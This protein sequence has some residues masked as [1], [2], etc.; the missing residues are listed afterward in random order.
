MQDSGVN[1]ILT[2]CLADGGVAEISV[3]QHGRRIS[4]CTEWQAYE[5]T[6]IGLDDCTIYVD[7]A[8]LQPKGGTPQTWLWS[9]GFFAG[10]VLL[11]VV[12]GNDKLRG[13]YEIVVSPAPQK[14]SSSEYS[15]MLDEI[16]EFKAALMLGFE[17]GQN[18]I[19]AE[20]SYDDPQLAYARLKLFGSA[21][22]SALSPLRRQPQSRLRY[23]REVVPLHRVRRIDQTTIRSAL[24][25]PEALRVLES[26]AHHA[27]VAK[28]PSFN[29]PSAEHTVDIP[30][31]WTMLA[32]VHAFHRRVKS[33]RRHFE[34]MLL[35]PSKDVSRGEFNDRLP[36]RIQYLSTLE[37]SLGRLI[38]TYPFNALSRAEVSAAGL[39]TVSAHPAYGRA[40]RTGWHAL[41]PGIEGGRV[42]ENLWS[43]PTWQV[44]ERWTFLQIIYVIEKIISSESKTVKYPSSRQD[45]VSVTWTEGELVVSAYLQARFPAYDQTEWQGFRSISSER[46]P[47]IVVTF[48]HADKKRFLLFDAKYR[49]SRQGVLEGM[50]SAHLYRDSLR[51][52]GLRADA[53]L[54][55]IPAEG[56]APWLEEDEFRLENEVGVIPVSVSSGTERLEAVLANYLAL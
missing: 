5:I 37:L 43:S 48:Q 25:N 52:H 40:Y 15:S 49:V 6:L 34:G 50:E 7:D 3:D 16:Y 22:I 45:F 9:A 56:G 24:K 36:R 13:Q 29:V 12:D 10:D 14:L 23:R 41:R 4:G 55:L 30:A 17:S 38:N 53:C 31:N 35:S 19:G 47:D 11:Q 46:F 2:V 54:L 28:I 27:G 21:F 51:W 1:P 20:G 8:K 33:V 18:A 26:R 32:L 39:N 44:Y 42:A